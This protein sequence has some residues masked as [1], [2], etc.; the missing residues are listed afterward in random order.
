MKINK[1]VDLMFEQGLVNE[2]E[3]LKIDYLR[4]QVK[5]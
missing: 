2:V 1:R 3:K 5:L 4:H